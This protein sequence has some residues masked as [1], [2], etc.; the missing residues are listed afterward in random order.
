M[1]LLATPSCA[2]FGVGV[3]PS[4]GPPQ[5]P[6]ADGWLGG[7]AA[8]SI[9][10]DDGKSVWLFGDTFV[11]SPDQHDRRNA[12]FIH[13]SIAIS[14]CA[15]DGTWQIEYAWGRATDGSPRAFFEPDERSGYWWLFDGFV[16]ADRLY[17]GLLGVE[18]SEP[19]GPLN[20]PFRYTG[21]KLA[22]VENYED[23]PQTWN[24]EVLPLTDSLTA[25]PGSSMLV[26]EGYVYLFAFLDLN[27][28][29]YPR[30]LSRLP[31]SAL[32]SDDPGGA[33][34]YLAHDRHWKKGFEPENAL[35]IH[36]DHG[37]AKDRIGLLS[38]GP[39][40]ATSELTVCWQGSQTLPS[41]PGSR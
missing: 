9:P 39:G 26:H 10:I 4:C 6:Y 40:W 8:Y 24:F 33:L 32:S 34:E 27:A 31:T 19:R 30:M 2:G 37:S 20:L 11:G 3:A 35:N 36:V 14:E 21:M 29:R 18:E 1:L 28:E 5:F 17:I 22:R 38:T 25:F 16:H 41:D 7:D 23:D 13:N 12:D 15:R